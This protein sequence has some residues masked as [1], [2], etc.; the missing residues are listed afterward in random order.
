MLDLKRPL[1]VT[2]FFISYQ[3]RILIF[4][5]WIGFF[6]SFRMIHFPFFPPFKMGLNLKTNETGVKQVRGPV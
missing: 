4:R 1:I 6:F 5:K 3:E 2:H